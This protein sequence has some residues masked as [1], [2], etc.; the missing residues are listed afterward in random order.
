MLP[1][2]RQHMWCTLRKRPSSFLCYKQT[3][4]TFQIVLE[5]KSSIPFAA[6]PVLICVTFCIVYKGSWVA[7]L[8]ST[9]L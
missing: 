2:V 9:G 4:R 6:L 1:S 7:I 3:N 5:E 8:L